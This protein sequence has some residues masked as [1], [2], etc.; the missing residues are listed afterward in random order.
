MASV[1]DSST[2]NMMQFSLG[3]ARR[4]GQALSAAG[5]G[6]GAIDRPRPDRVAAVPRRA[7]DHG[8]G[9][10][11]Q[12]VQHIGESP[13]GRPTQD[14]RLGRIGPEVTGSGLPQPRSDC[15]KS[16]PCSASA[17]RSEPDKATRRRCRYHATACYTAAMLFEYE[18]EARLEHA[19]ATLL[20][21]PATGTRPAGFRCGMPPIV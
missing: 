20:A 15:R 17:A 10:P 6:S 19:G 3:V 11:G 18:I 14:R 8:N 2:T 13:A 1:V 21:L 5:S 7:A 9:G 12:T 4:A 16:I